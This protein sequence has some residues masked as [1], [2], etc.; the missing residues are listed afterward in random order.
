MTPSEA[1][2]LKPGDM[3]YNGSLKGAVYDAGQKV[4]TI[5]WTHK[6]G[7]DALQRNSPLWRYLHTE[8][9]P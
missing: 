4:V 2:A 7:L 5:A 1:N 8:P 9:K 3:V 6:A